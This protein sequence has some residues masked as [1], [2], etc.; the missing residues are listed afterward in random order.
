MDLAHIL[1]LIIIVVVAIYGMVI[2][3]NEGY[4]DQ[5]AIEKPVQVDQPLVEKAVEI[6]DKQPVKQEIQQEDKQSVKQQLKQEIQQED[7]QPVKQQL[8]QEIQQEDRQPVKQQI[9]ELDKQPVKQEL[10]VD[11]PIQAVQKS[12]SIPQPPPLTPLVDMPPIPKMTKDSTAQPQPNKGPDPTMSAIAEPAAPAEIYS[13]AVDV[14]TEK[15]T[16]QKVTAQKAPLKPTAVNPPAKM[17]LSR[18]QPVKPK[19]K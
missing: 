15:A 5:P 3:M 6:T 19:S 10:Q 12:Q 1:I 2:Y 9:V 11:K 16:A 7:K 18:S 4:D 13:E 14:P 8:K 17:V